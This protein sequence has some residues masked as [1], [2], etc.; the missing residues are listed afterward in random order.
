[1]AGAGLL[2]IKRR[3]KSITNTQKITRAMGLVATAKFR[4]LRERAGDI[5]IYYDEYQRTIEEMLKVNEVEESVYLQKNSSD[6]DLYIVVT[7]DT[8]L[9][10][11]YNANVLNNVLEH[12]YQ[13]KVAVLTVGERGRAFFKKRNYET[14]AEFVEIGDKP[15]YKDASEIIKPAIDEFM[16][17]N[18]RSVYLAYTKFITSVKQTVE[19]V[20][21]L[22]FERNKDFKSSNIEFDPSVTEVMNYAI[23]KYLYATMYHAL[24]NSIASE[25]AI[26]MSAMDNATKNTEKL[27]EKLKIAYNRARQSNI[28]QEIT[29][30]VSGAE[31]LKE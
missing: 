31:A 15:S 2:E 23:P 11:S 26:R 19:I 8:G 7:S 17:G 18:V 29:E 9:C 24:V 20:K 27:L 16:A 12:M 14:V 25:Y 30:I 28:T 13:K 1:M 5:D 22:P 6:I 3:I 10:G 21:L 4:K